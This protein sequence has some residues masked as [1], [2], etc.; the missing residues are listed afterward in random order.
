MQNYMHWS[1]TMYCK[2]WGLEKQLIFQVLRTQFPCGVQLPGFHPGFP[3]SLLMLTVDLWKVSGLFC[4]LQKPGL[5]VS[6]KPFSHVSSVGAAEGFGES[7][8]FKHTGLWF[9]KEQK[10]KSITSCRITSCWRPID[11]TSENNQISV[12]FSACKWLCET[13]KGN[14][15]LKKK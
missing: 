4:S 13:L 14:S 2:L 9:L 6:L 7:H 8:I 5:H 12:L 1:P 15:P 11:V 10:A 3:F